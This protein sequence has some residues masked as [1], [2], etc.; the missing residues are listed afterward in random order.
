V[1]TNPLS[2]VLLCFA[3][4]GCHSVAPD[5]SRIFYVGHGIEVTRQPYWT[6]QQIGPPGGAQYIWTI[7]GFALNEM[8]FA[9][10]ISNGNPI[11]SDPQNIYDLPVYRRTMLPDDVMELIAATLR[12]LGYQRLR[13]DALHPIMFGSAT[14]FRFS[15]SYATESGLEMKGTAVIAQRGRLDVIL[16]TAPGEYY[17]DHYLPTVE[18]VFASIRAPGAEP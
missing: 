4:A 13:T 15:F 9:T 8:I 1:R 10:G 12:K 6:N 2:A 7:D 18:N 14:G 16:F 5:G 17:F 3:L 11:V